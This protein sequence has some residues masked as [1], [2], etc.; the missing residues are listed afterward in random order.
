MTAA[1]F[2]SQLKNWNK[3][4]PQIRK[5]LML[6]FKGIK[7]ITNLELRTNTEAMMENIERGLL[8][9]AVFM[10]FIKLSVND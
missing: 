5:S 10:E 3:S 8:D 2:T 4:Q 9:V 6:D 7:P 1:I